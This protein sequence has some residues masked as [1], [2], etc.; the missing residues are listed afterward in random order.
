MKIQPFSDPELYLLNK[1]ESAMLLE[2]S[3]KAVR[4]KYAQIFTAALDRLEQRYKGLDCRTMHLTDKWNPSVSI[5]KKSWPSMYPSW[6]SGFWLECIGLDHLTS[7]DKDAPHACVFFNPPKSEGRDLKGTVQRLREAAKTILTKERLDSV[8]HE[9]GKSESYI[10]YP[11]PE[12]R[13]ELQRMLMNNQSREFIDCIVAHLE[14]LEWFIPVMDEISRG[15]K[16]K[17][18]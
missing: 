18:K 6:P 4:D 7:Q 11:L 17:G 13:H 2:N 10:W 14:T 16:R 5:G 9:I 8:G 3:M 12:P 15:G 1:W